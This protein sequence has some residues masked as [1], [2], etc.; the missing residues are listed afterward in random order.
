MNRRLTPRIASLLLTAALAGLCAGPARG[1]GQET[2][3]TGTEL[4]TWLDQRFSYA[5][6]HAGSGCYF[7]NSAD[8]QG[9]VLFLACPNGWSSRIVGSA[10][11]QGDQLCTS[12]VVPNTPPGEECLSWHRREDG[13]YVQRNGTALSASLYILGSLRR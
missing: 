5:G 9:R 12:F 1:Q 10:R 7:M 8:P 11:V 4:Q 3:V 6:L 2:R 13:S